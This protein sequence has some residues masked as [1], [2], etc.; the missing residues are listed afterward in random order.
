MTE[1]SEQYRD[2]EEVFGRLKWVMF[3]RVVAITL[4]LGATAVLELRAGASYFTVSLVSIYILI[5]VTYLF[6]AVSGLILRWIKNPVYFAYIQ[7]CYEIL[8]ITALIAVTGRL[9]S[10]VYILAILSAG[11]LLH[12]SGALLGA[13]LSSLSYMALLTGVIKL[14]QTFRFINR[15]FIEDV[16]AL[17]STE[18]VYNAGVDVIAFFMVGF[19]ASYLTEKLRRT[20]IRLAEKEEDLEALEAWNEN[21][22]RSLPS[23]LVTTDSDG[24]VTSF[25]SAA[26]NITGGKASDILGSPL[27]KLF[28]QLHSDACPPEIS[29]TDSQGRKKFLGLSLSVL[30]S[31]KGQEIGKILTFQDQTPYRE[32]E[33]QL[34]IS[35]RLAVVG[36]LAAGLA[37]EIRNP[38]ASI[39]GSIQLLRHD[40]ETPEDDRLLRIILRETER[41]NLL[42]TEFLHFAKPAS[43]QVSHVNLKNVL[44]EAV[45][46]FRHQAGRSGAVKIILNCPEKLEVD[47]DSKLLN[48]VLWN[49]LVNAA[50]AMP[51]GGEIRLT[52][53]EMARDLRSPDSH[54]IRITLSDTGPGIPAEIRD[55]VFAPF[56]TTKEFGTGL[57]LATVYRSVESMGGRIRLNTETG[58]GTSFLIDLP[59]KQA[60]TERIKEAVG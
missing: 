28:P 2:R 42:I 37:H 25:N 6:T 34:K 5:S 22:I 58:R 7:V 3:L 20:N 35:D 13:A 49:L 14:K 23:G 32:M 56:F 47:L 55:K 15:D 41:L 45:E 24:L 31:S 40:M 26:E 27:E 54:G 11:I 50:E 53:E 10:F 1:H 21:V 46:L 4:L 12:R 33:E 29:F 51:D 8:L 52:V 57:G 48:Q 18:L 44:E 16:R 36:Q 9:F 59:V 60:E 39:S 38:L 17:N 30:R 19:L 43:G